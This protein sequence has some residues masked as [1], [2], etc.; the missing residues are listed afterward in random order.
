M[1]EFDDCGRI[2]ELLPEYL[3]GRL[4]LEAGCEV[5]R[6]LERCDECRGKAGTV[7]LLLQ[8]PVPGPAPDRWERF[9]EGVVDSVETSA[10]RRRRAWIPVAAAAAVLAIVAGLL[11]REPSPEGTVTG[12][13]AVAREVAELPEDEIA[14]WTVGVDPVDLMPAGPDEGSLSDE[15]LREL[16]REVGRT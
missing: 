15:E 11:F 12:L 7:D 8:T 13:E 9:V 1:S 6:H 14:T 3:A 4:E 16:I 2:E 5:R 10:R